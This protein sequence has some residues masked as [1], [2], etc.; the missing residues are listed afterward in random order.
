MKEI[1][2]HDKYWF[3]AKRYGWGWGLPQTWQGWLTL[4]AFVAGNIIWA[5]V[6]PPTHW[7]L[8]YPAGVAILIGGLLGICLAK[9]EPPAWH[10]GNS[11]DLK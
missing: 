7:P 8:L 2:E 11:A 4:A 5:A 9:G 3:R 1:P 10:W 6:V